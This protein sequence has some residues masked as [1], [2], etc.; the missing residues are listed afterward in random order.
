MKKSVVSLIA[1]MPLVIL[2]CGGGSAPP[3]TR[4]ADA[5]TP[6]AA[7]PAAAAQ[8]SGGV[9]IALSL[10]GGPHQG[11]YTLDHTNPCRFN[12]PSDGAWAL[13]VTFPGATSGPSIIDLV[14]LEGSSF[15]DTW[16]GDDNFHAPD[17]E[18]TVDDR[19]ETATLSATG[20]A[21]GPDGGQTFPVAITVE[22][23]QVARY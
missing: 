7:T 18:F 13:T 3:S 9:R 11:D 2:A 5:A 17:V 21:S 1:A 4:P 20:E 16:F 10:D 19:G 6:A 15:V 14:M 23:D 22:C 8:G 12:N